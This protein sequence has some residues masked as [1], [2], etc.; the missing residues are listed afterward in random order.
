M[1][2]NTNELL[3]A[4]LLTETIMSS[5]ID[6][7]DRHSILYIINRSMTEIKISNNSKN[8]IF[9]I[10]KSEM[11]IDQY[12]FNMLIEICEV[13]NTVYIRQKIK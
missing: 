11:I 5:I 8:N 3:K 12:S 6:I 13:D 10:I 1:K 9:D 2:D 4:E 7:L